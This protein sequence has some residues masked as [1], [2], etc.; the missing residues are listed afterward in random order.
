MEPYNV[1]GGHG[2]IIHIASGGRYEKF[3]PFPLLNHSTTISMKHGPVTSGQFQRSH[4]HV[5]AAISVD[6]LQQQG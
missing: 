1:P 3:R 6:I 5:L 2:A 4:H